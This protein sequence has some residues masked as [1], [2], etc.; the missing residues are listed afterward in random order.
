MKD[1]AKATYSSLVDRRTYNGRRNLTAYGAG[2]I[3]PWGSPSRAG[4]AGGH[5]RW[6]QEQYTLIIRTLMDPPR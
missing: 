5:F 4:G 2:A 3:G 1:R 6:Y